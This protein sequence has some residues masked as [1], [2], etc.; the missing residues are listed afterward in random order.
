MDPDFD[1]D[2]LRSRYVAAQRRPGRLKH[3][4]VAAAERGDPRGARRAWRDLIERASA[5]DCAYDGSAEFD[6]QHH[7]DLELVLLEA[8]EAAN[9]R[10]YDHVLKEI[11]SIAPC[12]HEVIDSFLDPPHPDRVH[13]LELL[14]VNVSTMTEAAVVYEDL[15][16]A[17]VLARRTPAE[18]DTMAWAVDSLLNREVLADLGM[19]VQDNRVA[20]PCSEAAWDAYAARFPLGPSRTV[21][22]LAVAADL[23]PARARRA[24]QQPSPW[25]F[26][27]RRDWS[28]PPSPTSRVER[29]VWY[30]L[31][32]CADVR[33]E[34][35]RRVLAPG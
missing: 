7:A 34:V 22:W 26:L 17:T 18:S 1:D 10:G 8:I 16:A 21:R 13:L 3:P 29:L 19:Q 33:G 32:A 6:D 23:L 12:M 27:L 15:E 31:S 14:A 2:D 5:F 20:N 9:A 11:A 35:M 25:L 28:A 4:M 24:L 30:T